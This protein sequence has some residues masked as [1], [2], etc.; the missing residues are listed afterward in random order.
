MAGQNRSCR[1]SPG[2]DIGSAEHL[3]AAVLLVDDDPSDQQL[4]SRLRA[5]PLTE[6]LELRQE[7]RRQ[8]ER[9]LPSPT[10]VELAEPARWVFYP[11]RR[12]LVSVPGPVSFRRLRLDRNRNKIS[13]A[14]QTR[15]SE[16]KI[17]VVG[18]SVGHAI[19]YTL[20]IEGLCGEL[21]LAD[22]DTIELSNLNRIPAS[23]LDIG[24]NKAVVAA[25]R[26]AEID[27]YLAVST[28]TAGL[29]EKNISSFLDGL[30]LVIEECD[31]L[32]IK[33]RVRE[34]ARARG[35]AVLM[36]TSD[37]GLFDVERFD[38]EPDR[39]L[40]HGLLGAVGPSSLAGL[41]T[42]DKA[43]HVMR[44]LQAADLSA[45]MAASMVEIGSTVTSWPQLGG[46]V[47]LGAAIVAAAVRRFG[48]DDHL[49]SG[50]IRVDLDRA[51]DQLG[52]VAF[53]DALAEY[54]RP[55]RHQDPADLTFHLPQD[56]L[57]AVVH[58]IRLAPSGGNSQPWDILA[59]P[60]RVDI[61]LAMERSSAMDVG[62]RGSYVA[63]G[64][65]GFNA[66]VAAAEFVSAAV[67]TEFPDD[68]E[69]DIVLSID[70][71]H[72]QL[73]DRPLSALYPS[74]ISRITNRN[75]GR[76]GPISVSVGQELRAAARAEGAS[77]QLITESGPMAE[78]AD[79]LAESDRIRYLTPLLH[80]E[81]MSELKWPGRDR[82]DTGIDVR[83]LGLDPVDLAKLQVASR[84]DVMTLL[85]SWG[86]GR[87]L[88]DSTR[89]RVIASSGLAIVTVHGD[90][91][92]AYLRGGAAAERVWVAAAG[93][94]LD[95]QPMS[96]VF[97]Y[98]RNDSDLRGLSNDFT[99]ELAVLQQRFNRLLALRAD[100]A[101]VLVLRFSHDAGPVPRSGRLPMSD[102]ITAPMPLAG[103]SP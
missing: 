61:R 13:A 50:R 89:D 49:P 5:D 36:D 27:P 83:T 35:I 59:I 78:L 38:F 23:I 11:W 70:L 42:R 77:V 6:V 24:V 25:R 51:L 74:M 66:R 67:I 32:D 90:S 29:T 8:L 102:V 85:A 87:A 45:R 73:I 14:E 71:E 17:G 3:G 63:I 88:G 58:A 33:V 80:R 4:L 76:R 48:R 82:L 56:P 46:D 47:A 79:I 96:P 34:A 86:G 21:R 84:A 95:V 31:S 19:A 93:R 37:R 72:R 75:T 9:L 55:G 18:L 69:S 7:M 43:P 28:V 62:H 65:A 91:A 53:D 94:N 41:A 15:L 64:A 12:T 10:T 92:P 68:R 101:P 99:A 57:A 100:E 97:L 26:I 44:I 20:A 81:M 40:F 1:T 22:F 30:D 60:G 98:A 39:P 16:L 52:A 2:L 54:E 103:V